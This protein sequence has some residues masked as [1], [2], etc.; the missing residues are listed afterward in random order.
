MLPVHA[1]NSSPLKFTVV[2]CYTVRSLLCYSSYIACSDGGDLHSKGSKPASQ[3]S[4]VCTR[5]SFM[6]GL[7]VHQP[8]P[9]GMYTVQ[10]LPCF[11]TGLIIIIILMSPISNIPH[12]SV[13]TT[14][15]RQWVTSL[16][17]VAF[18][19]AKVRSK[20]RLK[21]NSKWFCWDYRWAE[22]SKF[23][24]SDSLSESILL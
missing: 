4:L 9:M 3:K 11:E 22:T 7:Q 23:L 6:D 2:E 21:S 1:V 10:A 14:A 12:E 19:W 15:R 5:R 24:L 8:L 18:R 20:S 17:D 16:F 13:I